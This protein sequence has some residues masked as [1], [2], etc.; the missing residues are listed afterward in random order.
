MKLNYLLIPLAVF[1]VG[2]WGSFITN[3]GLGWYSKIKLPSYTPAGS[4]IGTVWTVI[5]ILTMISV[6]IVWNRHFDQKNFWLIII[7]FAINGGLNIFWSY[8]F[9][10]L[11]L[12]GP[13]AFE[14][15]LLGL[16]VIALVILIWPFS[17]AAAILLL[18][19]A[20]WVSFAAYLTYT[21]WN[22]NR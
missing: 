8:L 16:S 5:F 10:G 22:L 4:V 7:L 18:P 21:I 20:G 14:A 2:A 17:L 9:F 3:G 15:G 11:H 13:A 19:Y 6:L 12:L 1:A